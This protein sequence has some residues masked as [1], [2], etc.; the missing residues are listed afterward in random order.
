MELTSEPDLSLTQ[1]DLQGL[2]V[3]L[4]RKHIRGR[5]QKKVFNDIAQK[6]EGGQGL[7]AKYEDLAFRNLT[8]QTR[9]S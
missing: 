3:A 7:A 6:S 1:P 5:S 8:L 2:F 4:R 9:T